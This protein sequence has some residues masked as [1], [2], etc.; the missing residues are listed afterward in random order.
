[1]DL[2]LWTTGLSL[3]FGQSRACHQLWWITIRL[4][5]CQSD[6]T[7]LPVQVPIQNWFLQ[8]Q[9][10]IILS[11]P[12][13]HT[14]SM[15]HTNQELLPHHY[16]TNFNDRIGW[17]LLWKRD[18]DFRMLGKIYRVI[19]WNIFHNLVHEKV[20]KGL[21]NSLTTKTWE[22]IPKTTKAILGNINWTCLHR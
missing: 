12:L 2:N 21:W 10:S 1:M 22:L 9:M 15:Q 4:I 8:L 13:L 17:G 16:F 5:C 3:R 14:F 20:R 18:M 6:L 19:D 7:E 11:N